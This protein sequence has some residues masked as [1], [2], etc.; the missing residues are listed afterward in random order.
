MKLM[1]LNESQ[2]PG[3]PRWNANGQQALQTDRKRQRGYRGSLKVII[4][5]LILLLI[6]IGIASQ[7]I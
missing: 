4:N 7:G 6:D 1:N 2:E 5:G 3:L